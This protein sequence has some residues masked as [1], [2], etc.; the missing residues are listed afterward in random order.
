MP[1]EKKI[2]EDIKQAARQRYESTHESC[3]EIGD[4]YAIQ[5]R[6]VQTWANREG[7]IRP[8]Q[9]KTYGNQ[10]VIQAKIERR[11]ES[12]VE[13]KAKSLSERA[14]AFKR[15]AIEEGEMLLKEVKSLRERGI[16]DAET[17]QK[18][19]SAYRNV[20]EAGWKIHGLD[21]EQATRNATL[22]QVVINT[23]DTALTPIDVD[24]DG[25]IDVESSQGPAPRPS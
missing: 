12:L 13:S 3:R 4:H 6:T 17:L 22:V 19:V 10:K 2:P 25:V 11:F 23:K 1:F 15:D 24:T 18:T 7:W 14:V 21:A 9:S 16:E 20:I 5:G 8:G